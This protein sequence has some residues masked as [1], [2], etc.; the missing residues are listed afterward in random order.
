MAQLR[1]GSVL[2]LETHLLTDHFAAGKD[3]DVFQHALAPI[4][5]A[6]GLDGDAGEGATELVDHQSSQGL[7]FDVLGDDE[8]G[9]A[10]L[11]HLLQHRQKVLNTH[12]LL[13]GDEDVR[14]FKHRF[15]PFGI[16]HKVWGDVA[17]VELHALSELQLHAEGLGFLDT[18][19]TPS[20]PTFW[21]AWE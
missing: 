2:E 10:R 18:S 5:K 6:R 15:H 17:L 1:D 7:A 13:V 9:L 12:D 16:G 14:V 8:Q 3:G 19:T 4:A 20:L 11:D 21:M